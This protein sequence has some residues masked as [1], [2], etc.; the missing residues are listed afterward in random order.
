MLDLTKTAGTRWN[1]SATD[2][3][4]SDFLKVAQYRCEDG[5]EVA[6]QF[7]S[8][9]RTLRKHYSQYGTHSDDMDEDGIGSSSLPKTKG[10]QLEGSPDVID[11]DLPP[12]V[13]QGKGARKPCEYQRKLTVSINA[14]FLSK[15][16]VLEVI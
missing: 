1:A 13:S 10:K 16:F 6:R 12:D 15:N 9:Y 8:H 3:F 14:K 5:G 2:V 11:D 7:R 4:V